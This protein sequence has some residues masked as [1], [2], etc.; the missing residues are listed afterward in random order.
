VLSIIYM[1]S[2]IIVVVYQEVTT[3]GKFY[4]IYF[5]LN[6]EVMNLADKRWYNCN[7][8]TVS[9]ISSPDTSSSSAYVLFY[10]MQD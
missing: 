4:I 2:H 3:F 9:R 10:V 6:S 7:D 1:V 5:V 8:S